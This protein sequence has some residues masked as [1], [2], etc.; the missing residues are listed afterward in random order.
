MVQ[1]ITEAIPVS[2]SSHIRLIAQW[3]QHPLS[4]ALEGALHMGTGLAFCAMY[5]SSVKKAFLGF[6]HVLK[7]K[8]TTSEA[9]W[10]IFVTVASLPVLV[11][12]GL[13]HL[14]HMRL[15]IPGAIAVLCAASGFLLWWFDRYGP[16]IYSTKVENFE[17]GWVFRACMLGA[18]QML[19]LFPGVSRL[20]ACLLASR[21]IG[22][23]RS[24]SLHISIVLGIISI[25]ACVTLEA[26]ALV[27]LDFT[28][29]LWVQTI[30]ITFFSCFAALWMFRCYIQNV[31]FFW[32]FLYRCVLAGL[33][34]FNHVLS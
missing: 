21:W 19:A 7:G 25:F 15:R 26:P 3:M 12:G 10:W 28:L 31:S 14:L 4:L 8:Y 22:Y 9:H 34:M 1:G 24:E 20:G 2:S 6:F 5:P 11:L 29:S 18:L 17:K 23:S 13:M 33:L 30:G 32:F 27:H 16:R